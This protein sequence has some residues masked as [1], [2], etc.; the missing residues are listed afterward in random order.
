[1]QKSERS[2]SLLVILLPDEFSSLL[3]DHE[4]RYKYAQKVE[5]KSK[6]KEKKIM[7]HTENQ[8]QNQHLCCT[9]QKSLSACF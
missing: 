8:L 2:Q 6:K 7:M 5:Q 1:V 3:I 9:T 4:S